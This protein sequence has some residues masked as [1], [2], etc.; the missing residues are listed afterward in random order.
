MRRI[1]INEKIL[2]AN[3]LIA[4]ENR[5][6]FDHHQ[7]LVLNIISSP[8]SG[9][10]SLIEETL[11][12]L[13]DKRATVI[14]GDIA[15]DLDAN[16]IEPLAPSVLQINTDGSCH[17]D[18]RMIRSAL[19]HLPEG[20]IDLILIENVGNLVCPAEF[21]VGE[22]HKVVILSVTEGDDKPL[23]YPLVFQLASVLVINKIDLIPYTDFNL[24][25][26]INLTRQINPKIEVIKL[27]CRTKEGIE[28]WTQ[29]IRKRLDDKN[30]G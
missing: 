23:K 25:R 18:A 24:V 27:S 1:K 22:D 10:T 4:L 2:S 14:E 3:D 5:S 30:K 21:K 11:R 15:G 20:R 8:G 19:D 26:F 7:A 16:R 9:K 6:I 13:R 12:R 17:L 28:D 29:W